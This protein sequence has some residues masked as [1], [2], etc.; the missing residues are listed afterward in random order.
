MS[1]IRTRDIL[2]RVLK[3]SSIKLVKVEGQLLKELQKCE[4][5]MLYE[6]NTICFENGIDLMMGGGSLLGTIRHQ[7][8]IPWDDDIDLMIRREQVKKFIWLL[9]NNVSD[10]YNIQY[11]SSDMQ[12]SFIKIR[13]KETTY[14]ELGDE[15][16]PAQNGVYLDVFIIE[17]I[18]DNIIKR[19]FFGIRCNLRLY[20][21][22]SVSMYYNS[23][24]E[25]REIMH[26]SIESEI[27]YIIRTFLGFIFSWRKPSDWFIHNN[28]F[29]S[30]YHEQKTKMVSIISGRGHFWGE[31]F[32]KTIFEEMIDMKFEELI[33][34]VP[35][36]YKTYLQQMY[37]DNYM[38]VPPVE[39]REH[40]Y[41]KAIKL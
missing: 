30:R 7:G 2:H 4:W 39:K 28:K 10:K 17:N 11:N 12:C 18:P 36:E 29:F 8:F 20:I 5:N 33:V 1:F 38:Q 24:N 25:Y 35:K 34:K 3:D 23:S 32:P 21:A 6:I 41:V 15:N 27:N 14:I 9:E 37:G 22:S 16:I 31:M 19:T 40:H 26:K 13:K